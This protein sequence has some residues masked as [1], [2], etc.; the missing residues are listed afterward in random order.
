M[1]IPRNNYQGRTTVAD[2][3]KKATRGGRFL[4][5]SEEV[6]DREFEHDLLLVGE[7]IERDTPFEAQGTER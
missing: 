6:S 1:S 2:S 3:R 4:L 7:G 5:D